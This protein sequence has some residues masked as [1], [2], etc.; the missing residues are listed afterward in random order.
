MSYVIWHGICS[1]VVY[2]G[3]LDEC[4]AWLAEQTAEYRAQCTISD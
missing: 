1:A 3:T 2:A 4:V